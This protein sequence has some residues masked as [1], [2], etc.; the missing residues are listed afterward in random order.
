MCFLLLFPLEW[1]APVF[2]SRVCAGMDNPR[3]VINVRF[4]SCGA[5]PASH[6]VGSSYLQ[7]Q[8]GRPG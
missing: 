6:Q 7:G 1:P 2:K 3:I 4:C 8:D 5:E